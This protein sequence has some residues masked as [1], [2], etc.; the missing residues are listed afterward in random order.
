MLAVVLLLSYL[1]FYQYN[2][3]KLVPILGL[4]GYAILRMVPTFVN[5]NVNIQAIRY[6]KFQI[7]E[8]I[9]N[10]VKFSKLYNE[11]ILNQNSESQTNK[12]DSKRK[13]MKDTIRPQASMIGLI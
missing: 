4:F 13:N 11:R 10:T 12:V 6:S 9:K 2:I 5:Y 8:V 3:I 7:D 1:E